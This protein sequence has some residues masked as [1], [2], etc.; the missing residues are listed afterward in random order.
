ML[1]R[2]SSRVTLEN[3]LLFGLALALAGAGTLGYAC[4]RIWRFM[5]Q[6]DYLFSRLDLPSTKLA[7]L[8]T[9]LTVTGIQIIFS[10]FFLSLLTIETVAQR[11]DD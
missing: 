10:S 11:F 2:F 6:T 1:Q 3:G 9:V 5:H 7:L 8:G 4:L